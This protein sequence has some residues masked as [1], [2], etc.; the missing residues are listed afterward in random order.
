M[1]SIFIN[2]G[3]HQNDSSLETMSF[4]TVVSYVLI[5]C[6]PEKRM[7]IVC[8]KACKTCK[9]VSLY[10]YIFDDNELNIFADDTAL[11]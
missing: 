2:I 9:L 4:G 1:K 8:N 10:M 11:I 7:N 5:H 6:A 3:L